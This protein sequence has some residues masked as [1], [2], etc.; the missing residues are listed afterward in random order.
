MAKSLGWGSPA[1]DFPLGLFDDFDGK[2]VLIEYEAGDYGTQ[3]HNS[4]RPLNY[5][6]EARNLEVPDEDD[7]DG[8]LTQGWYGM[9]G[10]EDTYEIS[11]DGMDLEGSPPLPGKNTR[12]T[13]FILALREHSSVK[14]KSLSLKPLDGLEIHWKSIEERVRNPSTGESLTRAVLYASGKVVG[15]ALYGKSKKTSSGGRSRGGDDDADDG[16]E[17]SPRK[18]SRTSRSASNREDRRGKKSRESSSSD[19]D[20]DD[21]VVA[22]IVGIIEEAGDSGLARNK[23]AQTLAAEEDDLGDEIIEEA[24]KRSTITKVIKSGAV[25][26]K[27]GKLYLPDDGEGDDDDDDDEE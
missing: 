20:V 3:I 6:Y 18:G 5:E 10:N 16:E 22:A 4:I 19:S 2:I 1:E 26:E 21:E 11:D 13:K 17:E 14:M 9:G 25:V 8:R 24:A 27:G 15:S 12:A 23:I 7:E